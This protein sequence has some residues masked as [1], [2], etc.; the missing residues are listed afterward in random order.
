MVT[1]AETFWS[2]PA[3]YLTK[4]DTFR[5]FMSWHTHLLCAFYSKFLLHMPIS[6]KAWMQRMHLD[7]GVYL[8]VKSQYLQRCLS[9][10]LIRGNVPC[11]HYPWCIGPH[12]PC[13]YMDW[14]PGRHLLVTS[15][16]FYTLAS[17]DIWLLEHVQSA[18]VWYAFYWNTFLHYQL[19]LIRLSYH[20]LG[21]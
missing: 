13:L 3:Q 5:A 18:S 4:W 16:G 8:F 21:H 19:L 12:R 14:A 1:L 6:S 17:V 7:Y 10:I 20:L 2:D 15:R 9:V 11:N